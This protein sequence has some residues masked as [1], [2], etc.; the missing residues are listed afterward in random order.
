[1]DKAED[2]T[3]DH[4]DATIS[5]FKTAAKEKS[6]EAMFSVLSTVGSIVLAFFRSTFFSSTHY[7][8][9]SKRK[10]PLKPVRM[11]WLSLFFLTSAIASTSAHL[12]GSESQVSTVPIYFLS[13]R[14][15]HPK[16]RGIDPQDGGK[17]SDNGSDMNDKLSDVSNILL[18]SFTVIRIRRVIS[19]L[20]F[21]LLSFTT[22]LV[23]KS[24]SPFR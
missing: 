7:E 2:H 13:C 22:T 9:I 3:E 21:T 14:A 24:L 19:T 20:L 8:T 10:V 23:M 12:L 4:L 6:F 18:Y 17:V 11:N 5:L 1:M 16:L 15:H